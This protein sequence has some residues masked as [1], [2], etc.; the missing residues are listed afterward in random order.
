[1]FEHILKCRPMK[2]VVPFILGASIM[3][4]ALIWQ[5]AQALSEDHHLMA[6]KA[7]TARASR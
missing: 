1:M 7:E 5:Q 2:K 3:A 4:V 6:A